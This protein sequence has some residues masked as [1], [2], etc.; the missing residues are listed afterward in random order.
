M[1]RKIPVSKSYFD[2]ALGR[3]DAVALM[4]LL[5]SRSLSIGEV[6]E[7][8]IARAEIV[9]THIN[10][11]AAKGYDLARERAQQ[12]P[13]G[14]LRGIPFFMKDTEGVVGLPM[15]VGSN[16][17]PG[18]IQDHHS[19]SAEHILS[20]G[21]NTIGI[22]TTPEFGLTGVT[23]PTKFGPAKN[24]WNL[25]HNAGGSSGGSAALVAAGVVPI[26]SANDGAGSIR[27]PA[28][29]CGL[30]GLKPTQY[31]I[32]P[33]ELP[34]FMPFNIFHQ[35]IVSRTVRDTVR[36]FQAVEHRHET[37]PGLSAIGSEQRLAKKPLKIAMF[38]EDA[39]GVNCDSQCMTAA[40]KAGKLCEMLGH[41]VE[42]ISNPFPKDY[43]DHFMLLWTMMPAY[44]SMFGK[45]EFG[46]EFDASKF[47]PWTNYLGRYFLKRAWRSMGTLKYLK[48]FQGLYANIFENVD[49]LLSP[50]LGTL[51]PKN[52]YL[53]P[54]SDGP[55]H[56]ER[57]L[58]FIPFTAYQNVA[59]APALTLPLGMSTEGLPIGVQF[60]AARGQDQIL[61]DLAFELEVAAPWE[62]FAVG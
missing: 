59:E 10:A 31:R 9:N 47:E 1:S 17:L 2:D 61:L 52:G 15:S 24:P 54:L 58:N 25:D 49:V 45:S 56:W 7:A 33:V 21:V 62:P 13:N 55:V 5:E 53:S 18:A 28:S 39:R 46:N 38:V 48:R 42:L 36:F 11:I 32:A 43:M 30:V 16:A 44:L 60:A 19:A 50:T 40:E 41:H 29:C 20:T 35:G 3:H 26:A 37:P 22:S 34:S 27:I 14:G 57:L 51:P 12:L 8:A 6:T 4:D 23:E